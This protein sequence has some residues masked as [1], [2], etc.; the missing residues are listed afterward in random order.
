MEDPP[1]PCSLT[2]S[3]N[4]RRVIRGAFEDALAL[5]HHCA[6]LMARSLQSAD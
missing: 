5:E 1:F 4:F 6:H 2:Q 3:M